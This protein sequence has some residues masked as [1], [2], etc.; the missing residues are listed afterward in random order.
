LTPGNASGAAGRAAQARYVIINGQQN[1]LELAVLGATVYVYWTMNS[2]LL[3]AALGLLLAL[4]L[5][6]PPAFCWDCCCSTPPASAELPAQQEGGHGCCAKTGTDTDVPRATPSNS[7]DCAQFMGQT[8]QTARQVATIALV[9]SHD[10]KVPAPATLV[11]GVVAANRLQGFEKTPD[12]P[13]PCSSSRSR[14]S[15]SPRA[16]PAFS[17]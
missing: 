17:A 9:D 10:S 14:A 2:R 11:A 5:A 7:C 8:C 6:A 4:F 1:S 16:P 15:F 12:E 13:P 3:N